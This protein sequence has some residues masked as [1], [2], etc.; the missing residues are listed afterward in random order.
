MLNTLGAALAAV[1]LGLGVGIFLLIAM[2]DDEDGGSDFNFQLTSSDSLRPGSV[3]ARYQ[4]MIEKAA[5]KCDVG[6]SPSL[7]AAQLHQE[8][9]FGEKARS[10]AD[11]RG[12]AQFIPSTWA[13]YKTDGNGNGTKSEWEPADAIAAQGKYMC[14]LMESAKKHPEY[15]GSANELALAG[16]NA[17][18]Y[19]VKRHHG[20]PPKSFAGGQ[21]YN[22]V[23]T[24]MASV[25]RFAAA[26]SSTNA[27]LPKGFSLP[28][29]TP[30]K[31]K[32]AVAW[33]L[34]A[35]GGMYQWGGACTDPHA[36][37]AKRMQR[38]DCSSLMQQAYR[39]AGLSIPR[40]TYDQVNIGKRVS[41]DKPKPGDLVFNAG[42]DGSDARPGHVGM[43]IGDNMIVEAPRSGVETRLV[44]YSSWRK[45]TAAITRITEVRRVVD[46]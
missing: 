15:N 46:W 20:V 36:S 13:K 39:A 35:R 34:K 31:V 12:I 21:T 19:A 8:S 37:G 1:T 10:E 25:P 23:R 16:Y 40:T 7:L 3:P 45:S 17:G 11:A 44:T 2:F 38:C 24:I 30:E 14:D 27:T 22:Y 18:W 26:K 41:M 42:S 28:S 29:G 33:A 4:K 6:L 9:G 5:E 43:Y 32:S